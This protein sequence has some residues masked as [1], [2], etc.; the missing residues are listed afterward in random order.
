MV[1]PHPKPRR[2]KNLPAKARTQNDPKNDSPVQHYD[3]HA[4]K[5]L[6]KEIADIKARIDY[7]KAP[8]EGLHGQQPGPHGGGLRDS[9]RP[10]TLG[11][12]FIPGQSINYP[13]SGD[14][15]VSP[16]DNH[17]YTINEPRSLNKQEF[18]NQGRSGLHLRWV[19][20]PDQARDFRDDDSRGAIPQPRSNTTYSNVDQ[21]TAPRGPPRNRRKCDLGFGYAQHGGYDIESERYEEDPDYVIVRDGNEGIDEVINEAEAPRYKS[22]S[23]PELKRK[24]DGVKATMTS[25]NDNKFGGGV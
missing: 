17:P 24:Q 12:D 16:Q 13:T 14:V 3:K 11:G 20:P 1:A 23:A 19:L 15:R 4:E 25:F 21:H 22:Q 10:K 8:P 2:R 18:E 7:G 9:E 6:A 5:Q